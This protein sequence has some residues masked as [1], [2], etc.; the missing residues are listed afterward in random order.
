MQK[1][2][3]KALSRPVAI[4][5][6]LGLLV[7][8]CLKTSAQDYTTPFTFTT[9]LGF[10][11][12][13]GWLDGTNS[14]AR[15]RGH[16]IAIDQ[17]G[18]IFL[19][20]NSN[21]TIRKVSR[22]GTNWVA[23]TIAGSTNS[24]YADGTNS[25][26]R[27]SSPWAI[28]VDALTNL[29][30]AGRVD[31]TVRKVSPQ[32][33]NWVVTTLAGTPLKTGYAEGTG[34][35]AMFNIPNG[36]CVDTNGNVYVADSLNNRIRKVTPAGVVSTIAGSGVKGY[37]D[38]PGTSARF[39]WPHGLRVDDQG[40]V[41]VADT[42]NHVIRKV[43]PVGTNWVVSTIG[44]TYQPGSPEP[45]G[46]FT[47]GTNNTQFHRPYDVALDGF[48]NVYVSDCWTNRCLRKIAPQGTNWVVST[49]GGVPFTRGTGDGMGPGAR[50][51]GQFSGMAFDAR[52]ALLVADSATLRVGV[53]APQIMKV[54]GSLVLSWA[55]SGYGL[56]RSA[57]LDAEALWVPVNDGVTLVNGTFFATNSVTESA[58]FFRL[59]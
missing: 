44:G 50:F 17:S 9:V 5:F 48:G 18:N 15:L 29:Y 41:F 30:I 1:I 33:T 36:I 35:N 8:P 58:G 31:Q 14:D 57:S 10:P 27:F 12:A 22:E 7:S 3:K 51:W 20:E 16:A 34:T 21:G 28:A 59:R 52:G 32:G 49:V 13:P 45:I 26:A 43:S 2:W 47:D 23:V 19:G 11:A 55:A 37:A 24:G 53:P 40:N 46:G 42:Y 38:G 25:E 56:E 39:Y 4:L 54:G 6:A